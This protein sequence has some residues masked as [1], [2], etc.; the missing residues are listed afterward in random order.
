MK[1]KIKS[2]H[3][4][5]AQEHEFNQQK[6]IASGAGIVWDNKVLQ[7]SEVQRKKFVSAKQCYI[8]AGY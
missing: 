1:F 7:R 6:G 5:S 8:I 2:Q 3:D 4:D